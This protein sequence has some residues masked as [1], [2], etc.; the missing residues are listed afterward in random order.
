[1]DRGHSAMETEKGE[2]TNRG[3]VNITTRAVVQVARKK[4]R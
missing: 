4:M 1:M 2:D 3:E